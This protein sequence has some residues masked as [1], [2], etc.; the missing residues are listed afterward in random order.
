M[1][2]FP[3][4]VRPRHA[5]FLEQFHECLEEVRELPDGFA[6]RFR[7][8]G[9]LLARLAEWVRLESVCCPFLRFEVRVDRRAGPVWLRLTGAE[10]TREFLRREFEI[11]PFAAGLSRTTSSAAE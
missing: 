10:G 5:G 1:G 6:L 3:R 2:I 9:T 11:G 7:D 4:R 8:D